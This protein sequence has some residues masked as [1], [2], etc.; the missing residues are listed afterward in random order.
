V[1]DLEPQITAWAEQEDG[2][3]AVAVVGSKARAEVPADE[4]SDLDVVIISEDPPAILDRDDWARAFGPVKLTFLEPT[5]LQNGWERRV[6]YED[7]TDVDFSVVPLAVVDEQ[8]A[9]GVAARGIRILVDKDGEL[10]RRVSGFEP[11]PPPAP[12]DQDALRELVSDFYYHALWAARKLA[13]GEVF[14]AK[15]CSDGYLDWILVRILE[16]H[17][18][19]RDPSVDT[20]HAGRFLERWADPQ[21]VADLGETYSRY[22]AA[23][24]ERA[25]YARMEFF[26]RYARETA[27]LLGLEYPADEDEFATT[28]VRKVLG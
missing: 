23:D 8:D 15:R 26:R 4:W 7:G 6:L 13:R 22:D 9:I 10:T 2:I 18:R 5:A 21:A 28:L 16:W 3:R 25:L 12:P 14:T 11:P 27:E 20:W 17:A 19:A 24:V 1:K